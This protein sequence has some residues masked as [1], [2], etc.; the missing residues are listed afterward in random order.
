MA[1][2]YLLTH[3]YHKPSICKKKKRKDILAKY[4][5]M[6]HDKIQYAWLTIESKT[7]KII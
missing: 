7:Y 3:G 6:K 1:P 2:I 5:K 4:N